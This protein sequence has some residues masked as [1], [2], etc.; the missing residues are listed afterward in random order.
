LTIITIFVASILLSTFVLCS[1]CSVRTHNPKKNTKFQLYIFVTALQNRIRPVNLLIFTLDARA[2]NNNLH[3]ERN[4][5]KPSWN[6]ISRKRRTAAAAA[7]VRRIELKT[8]RRRVLRLFSSKKR[9]NTFKR[10]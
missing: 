4:R 5:R 2:E 7:A 6:R 9:I 3:F 8:A 1:A 10:K